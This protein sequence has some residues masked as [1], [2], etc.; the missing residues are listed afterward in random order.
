MTTDAWTLDLDGQQIAVH[1]YGDVDA[2]SIIMLHSSGLSGRQWKPYAV[3]LAGMGFQVHL[4][5]LIGY[6]KSDPWPSA[7][8]FDVAEEVLLVEALIAARPAPQVHLVGHSYGG[9]IALLTALKNQHIASVL[10]YEPVCWGILADQGS[11]EE[12]SIFARFEAR[13][14]FEDE[15][16][17]SAQWLEQFV[18]Y[19]NGE[20][21]WQLLPDDMRQNML[22][23]GRKTF[24]EVRSLCFDRTPASAYEGL[25]MPVHVLNGMGSPHEIQRIC[26]YLTDAIPNATS[27]KFA[28]GHMGPVTHGP[29]IMPEI[30]A[31]FECS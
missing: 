4:P 5:D 22:R 26:T 2:P 30:L 23:T 12:T 25:G 1:T 7:H 10:V 14:F 29:I 15:G 28:A 16:G 6:G 20:G 11:E 18:N 8:A 31:W 21:V 27:A 9:L 3:A 24:E 13:G 17:G 19:W